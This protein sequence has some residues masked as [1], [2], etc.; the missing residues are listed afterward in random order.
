MEDE[1][2]KEDHLN[3]TQALNTIVKCAKCHLFAVVR[4]S[5]DAPRGRKYLSQEL[6]V[7]SVRVLVEEHQF[8]LIGRRS[9]S[10]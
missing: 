9:C 7:G 2:I 6:V 1:A 5:L 8:E 3:N 4:V 10:H